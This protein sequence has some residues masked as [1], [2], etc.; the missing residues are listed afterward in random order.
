[1]VTKKRRQGSPYHAY[2]LI[3]PG[4]KHPSFLSSHVVV[5][6][7]HHQPGTRCLVKHSVK[8]DGC[9]GQRGGFETCCPRRSAW[10]GRWNASR[11]R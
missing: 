8:D 9:G 11:A 5:P 10:E 4:D 3:T 7:T 2:L 1:V 6:L